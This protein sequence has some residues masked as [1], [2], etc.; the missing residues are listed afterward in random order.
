MR[1]TP[2]LSFTA[3]KPVINQ[4]LR[5]CLYPEVPDS[6]HAFSLERVVPS[7]FEKKVQ[8]FQWRKS[9]L[10]RIAASDEAAIFALSVV[11]HQEMEL[12]DFPEPILPM[13]WDKRSKLYE[14]LLNHEI[15][16]LK[17]KW[18]HLL[19]PEKQ[20]W[21]RYDIFKE[22]D[23]CLDILKKCQDEIVRRCGFNPD[24]ETSLDWFARLQPDDSNK[25]AVFVFYCLR[26]QLLSILRVVEDHWPDQLDDCR[27]QKF[28]TLFW[29]HLNSTK[30]QRLFV[31]E[32]SPEICT[33]PGC[34]HKWVCLKEVMFDLGIL[35]K[36]IYT[37]KYK[38]SFRYV[39]GLD[40]LKKHNIKPI[41]EKRKYYIKQC[42]FFFLKK[43]YQ[44]TI[45]P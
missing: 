1:N 21:N 8:Y 28:E 6:Y 5:G 12:A 32:K 36:K 2:K 7:F 40:C 20:P 16:L 30:P 17:I 19:F 39:K 13:Q 25:C 14:L 44:Q 41:H 45:N 34:D 38:P 26:N 9:F 29:D 23:A 18:I 31:Q 35:D 3:E 24:L 42:D 43:I 4:V 10:K 22:Y 27:P 37:G 33:I 15:D 11:P